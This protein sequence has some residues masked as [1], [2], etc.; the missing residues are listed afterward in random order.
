MICIGTCINGGSCA[1]CGYAGLANAC[2]TVGAKGTMNIASAAIVVV[3][4]DIGIN[5]IAV[6]WC[7]RRYTAAILA[8]TIFACDITSATVQRII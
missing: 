3:T 6:G 4:P 7:D 2:F 1:F 8:Y 5:A